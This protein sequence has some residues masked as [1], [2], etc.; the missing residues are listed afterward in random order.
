MIREYCNLSCK[1]QPTAIETK[2]I[3]R[4]K[5]KMPSYPKT[6][7]FKQTETNKQ[8]K[9]V[10]EDDIYF[11]QSSIHIRGFQK[12]KQKGKKTLHP[13]RKIHSRTSN[14]KREGEKK[15]TRTKRPTR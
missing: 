3:S 5:D 13:N 10:E 1:N 9:N 11:D 14:P 12:S 15:N 6:G 8:T 2:E 7:S 4:R